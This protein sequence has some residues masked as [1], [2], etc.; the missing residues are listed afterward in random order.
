MS[1]FGT[2]FKSWL[3]EQLSVP[4]PEDIEAFSINLYELG[5]PN[6]KFG[7]EIIGAGSFNASNEDWACDEVWQP[8]TRGIEIPVGFSGSDWQTCLHRVKALLLDLIVSDEPLVAVIKGSRGLGLGF[9]D[10]DLEIIWQ[11]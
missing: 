5:E 1:N 2:T 3:S 4:I 8:E 6:A 9:V 10:G 11:L 7:V